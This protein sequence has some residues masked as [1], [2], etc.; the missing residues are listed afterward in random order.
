MTTKT[1]KKRGR[2]P[3]VIDYNRVEYLASLNMGIMDITR[4]IG[5]GWDTFNKHRNKKNSELADA[6]ARG[7]AKGLQLATSKLMEKIEDG[8]FNSIQFY[9]KSADRDTW[10]EKT[11]VDHNL[12]LAGILDS[13][14]A[15]VIDHAPTPELPPRKRASGSDID[16]KG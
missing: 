16:N 4:A 15:R 11:Q 6:L 3:I 5:V 2:K 12:N 7:R 1:P 8:D 14:R 13:A 10:A 9:L